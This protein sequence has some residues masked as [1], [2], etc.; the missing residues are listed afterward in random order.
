MAA[1]A[2]LETVAASPMFC[3]ASGREVGASCVGSG[4]SLSTHAHSATSA[5]G[6]TIMNSRRVAERRLC[7]GNGMSWYIGTTYEHLFGL[8]TVEPSPRIDSKYIIQV[9][10]E[11]V[12][13][14]PLYPEQ[15]NP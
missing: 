7:L 1:R 5:S 15:L 14:E 3:V 12:P 6:N 4:K 10:I 13:R 8:A 9:G 2:W 11:E